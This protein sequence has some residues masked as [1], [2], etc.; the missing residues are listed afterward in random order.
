[1]NFRNMWKRRRESG[2]TARGTPT[3]DIQRVKH[4]S[5]EVL[6]DWKAKVVSVFV[7]VVTQWGIFHTQTV[8]QGDDSAFVMLPLL[9]SQNAAC[10]WFQGDGLVT[11]PDCV[12]PLDLLQLGKPPDS[13]WPWTG[14]SRCRKWMD[15]VLSISTVDLFP[16]MCL[17]WWFHLLHFST[18]CS[19]W[20][21]DAGTS[22]SGTT[23]NFSINLHKWHV[24]PL[25]EQ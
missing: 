6:S 13:L 20:V 8:L 21:V 10:V 16:R 5:T 23:A 3:H 25:A 4:L 2:C 18:G 15:G 9:T 11:C 12:L 24:Q 19:G 1:M 17:T 22:M 7:F 14:W